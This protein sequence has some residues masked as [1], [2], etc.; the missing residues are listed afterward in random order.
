MENDEKLIFEP[1]VEED[2]EPLTEIMTRAFDDDTKRHIGD[3][4]GGPDGY[5]NGEFIKK[6]ALNSPSQSFKVLMNDKLIGSVILWINE[7][8]KNFLGNIFVDPSVQN[9]GIGLIIWNY[10]ETKYP[11]TRRWITETP[12][13]SKRNHNFYVNKCGFKIVKILNAGI[14]REESYILQKNMIPE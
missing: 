5:D 1:I 14:L 2:I 11:D 7:D 12:G 3:E 8:R 9:K 13:Y 10:I 6:W 4:K